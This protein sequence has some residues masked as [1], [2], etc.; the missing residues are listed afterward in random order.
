MRI[1]SILQAKYDGKGNVLF[2]GNIK[3]EG[4]FQDTIVPEGYAR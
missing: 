4:Q 2:R 3:L 1:A